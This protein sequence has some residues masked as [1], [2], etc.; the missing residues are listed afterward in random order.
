MIIILPITVHPKAPTATH[1]I[2]YV[3]IELLNQK[4]I[5][6]H[7]KSLGEPSQQRGVKTTTTMT[8]QSHE[9]RLKLSKMF[10]KKLPQRIMTTHPA[11]NRVMQMLTEVT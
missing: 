5:E 9:E 7:Q 6:T 2:L 3:C 10:W 4:N 11:P 8:V 1:L